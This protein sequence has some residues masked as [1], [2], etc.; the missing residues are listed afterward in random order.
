M[1]E[2]ANMDKLEAAVDAFGD[3]RLRWLIGKGDV[4]IQKGELTHER[5]QELMEQTVREEIDRSHIM[6]EIK[7]GPATITEIAKAT[8][9]EKDYIL[10]NLLALM[11][12]NMVEIV[13]DESREYI[14]ARKE[15]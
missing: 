12:W 3:E 1:K 4:L 5:L 8:K 15:I 13:G 10:E 11:K 2:S 9:M 7:D 14:Y 6:R